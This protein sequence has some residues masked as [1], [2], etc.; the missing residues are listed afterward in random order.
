MVARYAIYFAPAPDCAFWRFGSAWIGRDAAENKALGRPT[1]SGEASADWDA[2]AL[3]TLTASPQLYGF[4]ATL[5]PPF[6]LAERQ[7]IEGL[8]DA[9][10]AFARTYR[11]FICPQ[12]GV[13][14]LGRFIAFRLIE[15]CKDMSNLASACVQTFEPFRA[16]LNQVELAKRH[17]AD[18]TPRQTELVAAWGYPY[19]FEEFR[20]HMTLTGA[21][22]DTAVR[23]RLA[24]A[25]QV[26][27]KA[28]GA[29]GQMPAD[30]IAVYEQPE[31]GAAFR[32]L[33][34][35]PFQA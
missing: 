20:F 12:V 35:F 1:L 23:T 2:A 29:D 31:P 17:A 5:K 25:L 26:M 10:E 34:R 13:A 15:P 24:A 28:S 21:I 7:S 32:L 18:L 9:A 22:T 30:A 16:P 6:R 11:P 3:E 27:A 4:H 14:A 19:V 33:R 8:M